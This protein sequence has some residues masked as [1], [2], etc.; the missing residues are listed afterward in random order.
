MS[1]TWR[2]LG[3]E[4]SL[5]TKREK[6]M[7]VIKAEASTRLCFSFSSLLSNRNN[8]IPQGKAAFVVSR[9]KVL[10]LKTVDTQCSRRDVCG[11]LVLNRPLQVKRHSG[12]NDGMKCIPLH[13]QQAACFKGGWT[14]TR[15]LLTAGWEG[16]LGSVGSVQRVRFLWVSTA[17]LGKG[18]KSPLRGNNIRL[19]HWVF[20]GNAQDGVAKKDKSTF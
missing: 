4:I 3:T 17:I 7:N 18:N 2:W 11:F 1:I 16:G 8:V 10:D 9:S 13:C 12:W 20:K 15:N 6:E 14:A 5:G 19:M